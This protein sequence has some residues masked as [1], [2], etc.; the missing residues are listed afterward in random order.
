[1]QEYLSLIQTVGF[2][3]VAF[4]L[5]YRLVDTT[6]KEV[7]AE[8]GRSRETLMENTRVISLMCDELKDHIRQK[9]QVIEMLKERR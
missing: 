6:L 9:D 4:L 7:R 2:P 8:M 5:M 3:I 1:M